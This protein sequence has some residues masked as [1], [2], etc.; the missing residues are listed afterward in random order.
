M[1]CKRTIAAALLVLLTVGF[2]F[3]LPIAGSGSYADEGISSGQGDSPGIH[4]YYT[5]G[6]VDGAVQGIYEITLDGSVMDLPAGGHYIVTAD[7]YRSSPVEM[8][9]GIL[10]LSME[11]L[12]PGVHQVTVTHDSSPFTAVCSLHVGPSVDSVTIP[13]SD[14]YVSVG[15]SF[16][17]I[18][19]ILPAQAPVKDVTWTFAGDCISID[20][21]T[22]FGLSEG[23]ASVTVTTV[24]GGKT[25]TCTVHVVDLQVSFDPCEGIVPTP[26][27]DIVYGQPY[28]ELPVPEKTGHDFDGWFTAA[29]NGDLVTAD[30]VVTV[31]EDQT[32]YAHWT[33]REYQVDFDPGEGTVEV[34]SKTVT[35][36]KAYG[37]LPTPCLK[38]YKFVGWYT[39][40]DAGE[41]VSADSI[42]KI[43]SKHTLYARWSL[44]AYT[45]IFNGNG[46]TGGSTDNQQIPFH[47][48]T[49]LNP[50]GY[51]R[52]GYTFLHWCTSADGEGDTYLNGAEVTDLTAEP[53]ITLYAI[54]SP[55]TY[56]VHF[57]GNTA[58]SGTMLDQE[59]TYD[60]DK[61]PLSANKFGRTGYKFTGWN[62]DGEG[63]GTSYA[64]GEMVSNLATGG[65]VNL[66]AQWE[67]GYFTITFEDGFGGV[68][69]TF[70]EKFG[71]PVV[72]PDPPQKDGYVFKRWNPAVP[73]TVLPA[74]KTITAEWTPNEYR[75]VF[76]G[77]GDDGT[78]ITPP[79]D[80]KF[81]TTYTLTLN[82]FVRPGYSFEYWTENEDGSGQHYTDGQEVK[83]LALSGVFDLYAHWK[84]NTYV[85][86][87]QASF[88]EL[89]TKTVTFDQPYG[90]LPTPE[91]EGY[92]FDGWFLDA[93][94]MYPV[95]EETIVHTPDNHVLYAKWVHGH[96]T[97][98][99]NSNCK[100]ATGTMESQTFTYMEEGYLDYNQFVRP[101]YTFSHWNRSPNDKG[102][103]FDDGAKIYNLVKEG[104]VVLYAIW[105]PNP[106]DIIFNG[107]GG[108]G[109]MSLISAKYEVGTV[110]I[111]ANEYTR[112]GYTFSHWNTKFNDKGVSYYADTDVPS[113]LTTGG[114]ITLFAI[115]TPNEYTLS[116]DSKGNLPEGEA[117]PTYDDATVVFDTVYGD[118]LFLPVPECDGFTFEGW[119][120][121]DGVRI[122]E[123]SRVTKDFDHTLH[124]KWTVIEY[125]LR[126]EVDGKLLET[127]QVAYGTVFTVKD[128]YS[129]EG[130]DESD[131]FYNGAV[132]TGT[133]FRMPHEDVVFKAYLEASNYNVIYELNGR[134]LVETYT[135][136]T[137]VTV[138]APGEIPG[139]TVGPWILPDGLVGPVFPMPAHDV[140]ITAECTPNT[141]NL[142]FEPNG[143][144]PVPEGRKIV[145]N[146]VYGEL[147]ELTRT[148]Y[149]FAGWQDSEGTL[150][151][152]GDIYKT[153]GDQ[154]LY[155][156]WTANMYN[157]VFDK[158]GGDGAMDDQ[159]MGY[160]DPLTPLSANKFTRTGY[161]FAG[162]NTDREG[163]GTAYTDKQPV[164]NLTLLDSITLYAQWEARTY[165]VTF[166][167]GLKEN[168]PAPI[169]VTY[170]QPY[171]DLPVPEKTGYT[172][173]GWF[174]TGVPTIRCSPP[175]GSPTSTPSCSTVT[176]PC[177][178]SWTPWSWSTTDL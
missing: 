44:D 57:E 16:D 15:S 156:Q 110:H 89:P 59:F 39:D 171:G 87:Y 160:D 116:F 61:V 155:A 100:D 14:Y 80:M 177:P 120:D 150:I 163:H 29:E 9:D 99:F 19:Q 48:E 47:T 23:T 165:T 169:T 50:N 103:E 25:D 130:Y 115:W 78:K 122:V 12:C 92:E 98:I 28:G 159:L 107:N 142:N 71:A 133:E 106:Y 172:Y 138:K 124:A 21:G 151:K 54:W 157:V 178:D 170:D 40:P 32:L 90:A 153:V 8:T 3:A 126:Y 102:Q 11:R 53:E 136:G 34:A 131:W 175:N 108:A 141:Y 152:S 26:S 144:T 4:V 104:S 135:Y 97:I 70:T 105:E 109:S 173:T 146:T 118:N 140:H 72:V 51:T 147:P 96:Y 49:A 58:D 75:V 161:K 77:N 101:G 60:A 45:V 37:E 2:V 176:V 85:V 137:D 121:D 164:N 113:T 68:Y 168:N 145:F 76:H 158:N 149:R 41:L 81:G 125:E 112:T 66:Y 22:V 154:T 52:D 20:D 1:N 93:D 18:P 94:Y 17:I 88:V 62:T 95:T 84:A 6:E 31:T 73:D 117:F 167:A 143:G 86:T 43:A 91:Y 35:F 174:D 82:R 56:T 30:T 162:W 166:D 69:S 13:E 67:L 10:R 55:N 132:V 119:Y 46:F 79:L 24:D 83:N 63:H 38:S 114:K 36:G 7:G 123:T 42:V 65:T 74:D 148:G 33:A 27:K 127:S 134:I 111:P 64:D 139:Y 5:E 128:K 129:K